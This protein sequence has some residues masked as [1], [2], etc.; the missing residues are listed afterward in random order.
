MTTLNFSG[1]C[2]VLSHRSHVM[3]LLLSVQVGDII[4]TI[5]FFEVQTQP[6]AR[7]SGGDVV[8][9]FCVVCDAFDLNYNTQDNRR[10]PN[11]A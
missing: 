2:D 3:Y 4:S 8:V 1:A 11:I 5:G 9:V 10:K 7:Q 6:K